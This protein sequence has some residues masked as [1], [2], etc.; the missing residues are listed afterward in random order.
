M[1]REERM[2]WGNMMF[3]PILHPVGTWKKD[4]IPLWSPPLGFC[5]PSSSS[6]SFVRGL[7]VRER[8]WKG[9]RQALHH[10]VIPLPIALWLRTQSPNYRELYLFCAFSLK[11]VAILSHFPFEVLFQWMANSSNGLRIIWAWMGGRA[12]A[13]GVG[14]RSPCLEA[15]LATL[16]G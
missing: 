11:G 14:A 6:F 9:E 3:P 13:M 1:R 5:G 10:Q 12:G 2:T 8:W 16:S 15:S 4:W 7:T